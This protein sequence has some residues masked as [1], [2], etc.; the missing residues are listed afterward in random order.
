MYFNK[1]DKMKTIVIKEYDSDGKVVKETTITEDGDTEPMII[2]K[3][4][5]YPP[6]YPY[7]PTVTCSNKT[8]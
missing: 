2:P 1:E 8:N 6:Y 5:P 7:N 3:Y 4:V